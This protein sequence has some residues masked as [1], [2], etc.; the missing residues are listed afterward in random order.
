MK[1]KIVMLMVA[2][3]II[4]SCTSRPESIAPVSISALEYKGLPCGET[5]QTLSLER[6]RLASLSSKQNGA[7][8]GDAI[9]VFLLGLPVAKILGQDVEGEIALS[10]GKVQ[11]LERAVPINC[12]EEKE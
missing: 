10:K 3:L 2:G 1:I 5:Q 9:G 8:T 12:R 6:S 4:S 11:A 7:A